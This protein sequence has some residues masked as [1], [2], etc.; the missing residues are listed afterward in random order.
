MFNKKTVSF[1]WSTGLDN[2]ANLG[3]HACP[4]FRTIPMETEIWFIC[5]HRQAPIFHSLCQS[6]MKIV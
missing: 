6:V 1:A 3:N 4:K 5:D 2:P